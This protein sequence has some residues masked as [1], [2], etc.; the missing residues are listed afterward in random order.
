MT[1]HRSRGCGFVIGLWALFSSSIA[2]ANALPRFDV[3]AYCRNVAG[4]TG[5]YSSTIYGSCI[6]IEQQAYNALALTWDRNAPHSQEYCGQVAKTVGSYQI[7]QECLK[8]EASSDEK[9]AARSF[10]YSTPQGH[11]QKLPAA[12]GVKKE[13]DLSIEVTKQLGRGFSAA[14]TCL[15]GPAFQWQILTQCRLHHIE[16]ERKTSA[17]LDAF[18]LALD[19]EVLWDME[20]AHSVA[21]KENYKEFRSLRSFRLLEAALFDEYRGLKQKLDISDA[22]LCEGHIADPESCTE[23]VLDP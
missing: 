4:A 7:L 20:I 2:H 18:K 11:Q 21:K 19:R 14:R 3:P 6:D 13:K 5:S 16:T 23:I 1:W 9:H 12:I 8:Q 22:D 10:D 17:S 15:N